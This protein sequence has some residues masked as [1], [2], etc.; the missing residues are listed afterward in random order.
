MNAIIWVRQGKTQLALA[1]ISGAMMIQATVPS[2]IGLLFT[3][4]RFDGA[5][6]LSGL[7]TMAAIGYLLTLLRTHRFT[8]KRLTYAASLYAVFA[9]GLVVVG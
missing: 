2:G 9:A 7:V 5:L 3:P 6:L 1:N 4:W 8:A